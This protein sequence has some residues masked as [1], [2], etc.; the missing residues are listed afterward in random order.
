MA[1][2]MSYFGRPDT[3]KAVRDALVGL[4]QQIQI[5]DKKSDQLQK[6]IEQELKVARANAVSDKRLATAA[7]RRKHA[8]EKQLDQLRGQQTQ[9]EVQAETLASANINA[10]TVAAMKKAAEVMERIHSGVSATNIDE[11]LEQI[12]DQIDQAK[13][14]SELLANPLSG[15]PFEEEELEAELNELESE[16]LTERLSHTEHVPMY[17]PPGAVRKDTIEQRPEYDEEVAL[18]E[19]QAE[20]AAM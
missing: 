20:L 8:H 9:L 3:K 17:I 19:L 2:I 18:R 6:R 1:G 10:E 16:A 5:L 4:Q 15:D 12:T 14:I 7:L 11:T 13:V